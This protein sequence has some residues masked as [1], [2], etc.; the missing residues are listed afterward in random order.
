MMFKSVEELRKMGKVQRDAATVSAAAVSRG[1]QQIAAETAAF[2]K[3]SVEDGSAATT[4]LMGAKDLGGAAAVQADYAKAALAGLMA[5]AGRMGAL[6]VAVGT[7]AAKPFEG[8]S[9]FGKSPF[10]KSPPGR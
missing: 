5:Q 4:R 6:M 8:V 1:V 9:P 3:R 10:G 2:A 7:E